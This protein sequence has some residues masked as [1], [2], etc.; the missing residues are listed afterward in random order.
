[1]S[2][3]DRLTDRRL[4]LAQTGEG[5]VFLHG[6]KPFQTFTF[7]FHSTFEHNIVILY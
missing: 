4:R 3:A 5:I 2:K 7:N 6:I 1:M